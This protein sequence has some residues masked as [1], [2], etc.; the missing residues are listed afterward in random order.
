MVW[1][2]LLAATMSRAMKEVIAEFLFVT[3]FLDGVSDVSNLSQWFIVS[4]DVKQ[5]GDARELMVCF[6]DVRAVGTGLWWILGWLGKGSMQQDSGCREWNWWFGRDLMGAGLLFLGLQHPCSDSSYPLESCL[7]STW[8]W[9]SFQ[10]NNTLWVCSI[11]KW[12]VC[13]GVWFTVLS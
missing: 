5:K 9:C 12:H 13:L 2:M 7:I 8:G 1:L 3:I 10:L 11:F 6:Q 4:L